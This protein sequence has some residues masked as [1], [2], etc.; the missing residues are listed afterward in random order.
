MTDGE[1][2]RV[3]DVLRCTVSYMADKGTMGPLK[4]YAKNE[5]FWSRS[6]MMAHVRE[7]ERK[8]KVVSE[9]NDALIRELDEKP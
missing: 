8:L 1:K 3:L 2:K 5:R 6:G 7:L 9:V 4:N